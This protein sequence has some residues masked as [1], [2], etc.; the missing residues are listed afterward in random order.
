MQRIDITSELIHRLSSKQGRSVSSR[1]QLR[2][3]LQQ[4]IEEYERNGG[5]INEIPTGLGSGKDA[6]VSDQPGEGFA[7]SRPTNSQVDGQYYDRNIYL[8]STEAAR[9]LGMSR[10]A[11]SYKVRAGT[12]ICDDYGNSLRA[13]SNDK[14]THLFLVSHL[15][16]IKRLRGDEC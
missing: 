4:Q 10:S 16:N 2:E 7:I 15:R 8:S 13:A 9:F 6:I 12:L 3:E 5:I 11:L 1:N 14:R